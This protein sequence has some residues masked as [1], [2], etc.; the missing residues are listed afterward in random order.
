MT[1]LALCYP[2]LV[3]LGVYT[4]HVTPVVYCLALLLCVPFVMGAVGKGRPGYLSMLL[5]GVAGLI[6]YAS[7][8]Y[9]VNIVQIH[10]V[11]MFSL[12]CLLFASTLR[13]G[14]IPLISRFA[15]LIRGDV[16]KAV[17]EY[18]RWAT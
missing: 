13:K 6:L 10:P 5:A 3:H 7:E 8:S 18:G 14:S 17:V 16:P 15:I 4:G 12:V 11:M 9:A 2:L 1:L